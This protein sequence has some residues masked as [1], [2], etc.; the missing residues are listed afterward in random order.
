MSRI[1]EAVSA[2][3]T[4]AEQLDTEARVIPADWLSRKP[5]PEVWSV[6]DNLC[7]IHEFVPY[8][9]GQIESIKRDSTKEWGR[10]HADP[11]R[12]AAVANSG[13]TDLDTIL[14]GILSRVQA[15]C[16]DLSRLHDE[17]LK[18]EAPSRNPRWGIKPAGFILDTLLVEHLEGHRRQIQRNLKGFAQVVSTHG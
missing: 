5:G 12:L 1:T 17:D 6:F 3:Q 15:A 9:V 18:I 2:L 13:G 11:D 7:H 16:G 10:T 8:W 4:N 14:S